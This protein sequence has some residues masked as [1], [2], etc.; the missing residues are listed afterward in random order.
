MVYGC[1][2]FENE[3]ES[4]RF[5]KPKPEYRMLA[6]CGRGASPVSARQ[7]RRDRDEKMRFVVAQAG[8]LLYR[9]FAIGRS[10]RDAGRSEPSKACRMQFCDTAD[11]KSALRGWRMCGATPESEGIR[12]QAERRVGRSLPRRP[13]IK[14]AKNTPKHA[15]KHRGGVK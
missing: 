13:N 14:H 5:P 6:G 11:C 8:S 4:G 2:M 7:G 12:W 10:S 9:Q 3:Q 15:K 1:G